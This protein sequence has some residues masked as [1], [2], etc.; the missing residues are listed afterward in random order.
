MTSLLQ[1]VDVESGEVRTIHETETHIEAPNWSPDGETVVFNAG[2]LIY[3]MPAQ[4]GVP[5]QID[6]G[7]AVRCNND[8][9]ISPDGTRIAISDSTEEGES[10]IYSL[11]FGGGAPERVT[12][13][14]PSWWHGWSPDGRRLAYTARRD[15]EFAIC[16]ID[17]GG[18]PETRVIGGGGHYDGPDYTP[19]GE[20]IWFNSDRSGT[21]QL[22]RVRPDGNDAQQMTADERVNWFPHPSPDG[23]HIAYLAYESGVEG[24]PADKPVELRL[25]PA[26]GGPPRTLVA[27]HGG[28]GTINVPSWAP[29]SRRFAFV[30]YA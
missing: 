13:D 9:G 30:R 7:F 15:G 10:C 20:W 27:L 5:V 8:H 29:D 1:W 23:R 26:G 4:G 14:I 16:T 6:T 21:M 28:Q 22:W 12:A 18:G 19:D 25:M 24:H 11:P 3:R 17:V 2:G